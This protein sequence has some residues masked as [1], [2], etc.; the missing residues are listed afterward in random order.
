MAERQ[1]SPGLTSV[2]TNTLNTYTD[3]HMHKQAH[4]QT[5]HDS[6]C[7]GLCT[8]VNTASWPKEEDYKFKTCLSNSVKNKMS[9]DQG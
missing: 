9:A 6:L 5:K 2:L 8:V 7:H 3:A 1:E 4:T